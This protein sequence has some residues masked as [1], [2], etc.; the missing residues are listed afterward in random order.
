M[1]HRLLALVASILTAVMG[2]AAVAEACTTSSYTAAFGC[3]APTI[4]RV[5]DHDAGAVDAGT[6]QLS[7]D[8]ER[9]AS[10]S[11]EFR[12]PS[13]TSAF[14]FVATEAA[15]SSIDDVLRP[16]GD[17]LGKAGSNAAI[18]EVSGGLSEAQA[19]FSQLTQ[20]GT[21]VSNSTYPGTLVRLPDG[22]TVGIRTVMSNSPNTAVTIDVNIP[23]FDITKIKFNP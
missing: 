13:T 10:P 17:L 18:R 1:Q 11:V 4:A 16:G 9:S 14:T 2:A 5:D 15:G 6:A 22:G 19:T 7:G 3:D 8:Q 23:G 20:G 21:V 12:G